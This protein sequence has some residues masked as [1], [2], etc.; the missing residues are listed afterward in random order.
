M[1]H[2][3]NVANLNDV[4]PGQSKLINFGE[5][6]IVLFN[7]GGTFYAIENCCPH[8]GGPLGK[9]ELQGNIVSCPWHQWRFDISTGVSIDFPEECVKR[10]DVKI[11]GKK[12]KILL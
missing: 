8:S 11:E 7:V 4:P 12:I 6:G 5:F 10:F 3:L 2:V 1:S 9:G